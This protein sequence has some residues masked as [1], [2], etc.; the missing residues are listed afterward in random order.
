VAGIV[1]GHHGPEGLTGIAPD[2]SLLALQVYSRLSDGSGIAAWDSDLLKALERV[3]A[4]SGQHRIAAVNLSLAGEA[5]YSTRAACD[6]DHPALT[7][8]VALLRS[9]NI[10]T[11][12][13][14]GNDGSATS[15]PAP[16]CLTGVISVGATCTRADAGF[17]SGGTDSTATFSNA[18][19]W[20][21]LKAPGTEITSSIPGRGYAALSGTSMAAPHVAGALAILRQLRPEAGVDELVARLRSHVSRGEAG[22]HYQQPLDPGA[23][24]GVASGPSTGEGAAAAAQR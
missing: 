19:P 8:A 13:A 11:V 18:P 17:C 23:I 12:A 4:L 5:L 21:D 15:L 20:L 3:Y 7:R 10:A 16:A 22:A 1:A 14:A 2:A 24:S 6:A 9:A